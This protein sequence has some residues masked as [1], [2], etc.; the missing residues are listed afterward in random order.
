MRVLTALLTLLLVLVCSCGGMQASI[1]P[2]ADSAENN[3]PDEQLPLWSD[4]VDLPRLAAATTMHQLVAGDMYDSAGASMNDT[5]LTLQASGLSW[6]IYS[7][8]MAEDQRPTAIHVSGTSDGVW[9][10]VSNYVADCWRWMGSEFD[11]NLD[12]G[13]MPPNILDESETVCHLAFVCVDGKSAEM[14]ISVELTVETW[15]VMFWLAGDNWRAQDAVNALNR[16]ETVGSTD[17]IRLLAGFDID[18]EQLNDPVAGTD[19]ARFIRVV[20]DD[21]PDSIVVNGDA[22]NQSFPRSGF[23]S[24]APAQLADFVAWAN[25]NFLYAS[26]SMLVVF[27]VGDGWV[28]RSTSAVRCKQTQGVLSDQSDGVELTN[29]ADL[30]AALDSEHFTILC[31]DASYMAQASVLAELND[32]GLADYY[33]ASQA[34]V[35]MELPYDTLVEQ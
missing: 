19:Q 30:A 22:A 7:L 16:L 34:L 23:D 2:A 10:G 32:H 21:D 1:P 8:A 25:D 14:Q 29:V 17:Q 33:I 28:S 5:T 11:G 15:N 20:N 6:V 26:H 31:F 24:S 13:V 3:A 9:L 18:P 4:A 27:G 35:P 12:V